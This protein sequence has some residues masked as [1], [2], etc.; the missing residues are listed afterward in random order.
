[1]CVCVY[2]TS[3]EYFATLENFYFSSEDIVSNETT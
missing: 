3:K 1:M 2:V